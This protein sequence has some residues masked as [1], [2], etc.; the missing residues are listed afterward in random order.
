MNNTEE[1]FEENGRVSVDQ[2]KM[3]AVRAYFEWMPIRQVDMDNN[4]RIWRS[5]NL[6]N[7]FDP[8]ILDTRNY[9]RSITD[10]GWNEDY[11][12]EIMNDAGRTMMGSIQENWLYNTLKRSKATW[13]II[14]SQVVFSTINATRWFGTDYNTDAWDGYMANKNRTLKTLYDNNIGNNIVLAGDT[15][16][17]WVADLTWLEEKDYDQQSGA[18]AVGVEFAGTAV[19]STSSCGDEFTINSCNNQSRNLVADNPELQWQEGYYRGYYEMQISK[20]EVRASYF[21]TPSLVTR[22]GYEVPLANFTIAAGDNR[23]TRPVGGESGVRNGALQR[24]ETTVSNLTL[25]TNTG[26]WFEHNENVL[27]IPRQ[28]S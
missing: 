18:G 9:D 2:R 8:I 10:L 1:S 16:E 17:N 24:K 28:S 23:L 27:N 22:N 26:R 6:G 25:D 14:G 7:L 19:S 20:K 5:F 15:H 4:L 13:R 21:G 3:N 11:I 12:P